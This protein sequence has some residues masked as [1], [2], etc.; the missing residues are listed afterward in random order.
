MSGDKLKLISNFCSEI[1]SGRNKLELSTIFHQKMV[2]NATTNS[3]WVNQ[4][5]L[6]MGSS[7]QYLYTVD[8]RE[9]VEY[10]TWASLSSTKWSYNKT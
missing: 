7:K 4:V 2:M 10:K 8:Y 6:A 9:Q 5:A 3:C 1:N